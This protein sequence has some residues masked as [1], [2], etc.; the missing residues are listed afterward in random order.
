MPCPVTNAIRQA[1]S[2]DHGSQ[3]FS[4]ALNTYF[5]NRLA[6]HRCSRCTVKT[7]LSEDTIQLLCQ[8]YRGRF[9]TR[10][11]NTGGSCITRRAVPTLPFKLHHVCGGR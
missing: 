5:R 11:C 7:G 2:G 1:R 10:F 9:R 4:N 6:K 3:D 8:R